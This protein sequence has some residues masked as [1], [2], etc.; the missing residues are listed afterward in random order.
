MLMVS[1]S[2]NKR[3]GRER[4]KQ[5]DANKLPLMPIT[6]RSIPSNYHQF[7]HSPL[8]PFHIPSLS[9]SVGRKKDAPTSG[10]SA[11]AVSGIAQ[12]VRGI[13]IR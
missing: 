3:R 4:E 1:Q 12:T 11:I 6:I 2:F 5:H 10:I 9:G 8:L 7:A 13:A